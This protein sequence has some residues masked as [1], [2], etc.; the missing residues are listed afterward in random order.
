MIFRQLFDS[1][2]STYTYL[3]ACEQNREAVLID[4][5]FEQHDRDA[6][7]IRELQLNVRYV[8]DTH[9][10]ADHVTGAWL[11]KEKL[12]AEIAVSKGSGCEFSDISLAEGDVLVFGDCALHIRETPGHTGGCI[13]LVT[14]DESMVFTG[15]CLLIRGTGRTDFQAGNVTEM[16]QSIRKRILSLPDECL[17]YPG[18]DY[19][20]R[21]CSTV[22]E[23]KRFNPRVGGEAQIE[24]FEGHMDNLNLAHP[25]ML[26]IAVPANLKNGK[27]EG[28]DTPA[29]T[30][31]GPVTVTFAGIP[32]IV[33]DWVARHLDEVYILDVRDPL[34]YDGDLGHVEGSNLIPLSEL[35]DRLDEIPKD[36]P[37]VALCQSGT[38]S[39]MA[40]QILLK[41]GFDQVANISGGLI[42]WARLALPRREVR[43]AGDWSI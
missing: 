42:R 15:D 37:I 22:A 9:V 26:D 34:E 23:E 32:E 31:W 33:P 3:L 27:P 38:R 36:R 24:D 13:T 11:A 7:L 29:N 14:H 20:G 21:T 17:I 28:S 43:L 1:D 12:G 35:R 18:H 4:T 6:A 16:W 5:V 41:A 25:K 30:D 40:A 2:S 8:I 19:S 39:G 10:H